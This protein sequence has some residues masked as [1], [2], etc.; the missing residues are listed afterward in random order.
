MKSHKFSFVG[1][2]LI[3]LMVLSLGAV[4]AQEP[5]TIDWWHI[6]TET[7]QAAYWQ[8]L[9]D[10]YTAENPHVTIDIT[11][12]ENAAFKDRLVTVMQAG[13]PPDLFQSWG[14]AVL[15]TYANNG[16]VRNIEP[17]L[18]GEWKD[19]FS[20][21][22][23][24]E[25]YGQNGEYYGVPW[26]WGA[27]GMFYNKALFTEA[28]LD[29]EN[30]PQTWEEFLAAVETLQE[31]GITPISLGESEKWPGHFW[32]VYLALRLGGE[33]AFLSAYNREGSFADEPF[34]QAGE[35]LKQL[36]DM[37][38]FPEG[39]L[40]L[41]HP[42]MEGIF[43]NGEAAMML[44]GQW[45][46]GAQAQ[47]SESGEGIGDENMGFFNFPAIEGGAGNAGDVLGGG[48]GFAVGADAPD[49]TIDFLKFITNAE[50]QRAG[51]EIFIVP[52]VAGAEDAVAEDPIMQAILE[53]RNNAPYFQLYYDQFLPPAVGGAVNDAVETLFAGMATPEEAA[54]AIEESAAFELSQ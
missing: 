30:P 9:A 40:G 28:G 18:A 49:E 11:I 54:Q 15:W 23:A 19:S 53:A 10:A 12:L 45:V 20:A 51:A 37:D 3:A 36:V 25:L 27:V 42:E 13:D 39:F 16:L 6:S 50:N 35:Y 7:S 21:E 31:A 33:D 14:G 48:D 46:P 34:V 1:F 17:E 44:M 38:P 43:G 24:L 22:A 47:Y 41:T 4:S 29:P 8:S 5:V 52:V 26:T 2:V 32:W